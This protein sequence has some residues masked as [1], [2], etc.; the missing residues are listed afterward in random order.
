MN[1]NQYKHQATVMA[2]P[3]AGGLT[4]LKGHKEVEREY[5]VPPLTT[6]LCCMHTPVRKHSMVDAEHI[7]PVR[8]SEKLSL[9]ACVR[10]QMY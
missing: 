9:S 5:K 4:T 2:R 1:V 8:R 6:F 10:L 3:A 7:L